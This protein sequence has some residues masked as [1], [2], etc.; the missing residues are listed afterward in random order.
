[1]AALPPGKR[2]RYPLYR[3]L[4]GPQGRYG[5]MRKISPQPGFDPRAMQPV[6]SRY[7]DYAIPAHFIAGILTESVAALKVPRQCPLV[8]L[9]KLR[10]TAL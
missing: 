10:P 8:L 5:R 1:M 3:W 6:A 2:P 7:T 9:V 4:G